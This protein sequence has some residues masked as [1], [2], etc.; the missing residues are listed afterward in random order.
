MWKRMSL[1]F[2]ALTISI[3]A[4]LWNLELGSDE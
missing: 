3:F 4:E 1:G 2:A